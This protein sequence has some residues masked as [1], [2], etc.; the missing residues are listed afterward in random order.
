[1]SAVVG[2][3]FERSWRLGLTPPGTKAFDPIWLAGFRI[4]G[5]KVSRYRWDVP[6]SAAMRPM[7][8]VRRVPLAWPAAVLA[9]RER[10][11]VRQQTVVRDLE[12]TPGAVRACVDSTLAMQFRGIM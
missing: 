5:R 10:G 4:N 8:T 1:V 2:L 3:P 11:Q 9:Y 12:A 6:S 7:R